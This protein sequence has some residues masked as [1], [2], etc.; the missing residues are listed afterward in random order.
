M[1]RFHFKPAG[2]FFFL[3]L[4]Q[5]FAPWFRARGSTQRLHPNGDKSG[6]YS[7]A[8]LTMSVWTFF[9]SF[10]FPHNGVEERE[11]RR[12]PH[13]FSL[14]LYANCVQSDLCHGSNGVSLTHSWQA[15]SRPE[16]RR[17]ACNWWMPPLHSWLSLKADACWIQRVQL[18]LHCIAMA[19]CCKK[20]EEI[21]TPFLNFR[22]NI[23]GT[24]CETEILGT[25]GWWWW[26][27]GPPP[28]PMVGV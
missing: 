6:N 26:T 11:W 24:L 20:K 12:W 28:A 18:H 2:L 7:A 17:L 3:S 10:F 23:W 1:G 25:A 15:A 21:G 27:L 13:Y 14:S 19:P 9:S 4:F 8:Q 5:G 22:D 16:R